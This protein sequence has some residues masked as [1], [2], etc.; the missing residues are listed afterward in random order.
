MRARASQDQ[1]WAFR[2]P[3]NIQTQV[4]QKNSALTPTLAVS[5]RN[6]PGQLSN[7]TDTHIGVEENVPK[8]TVEEVCLL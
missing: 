1:L 5:Q 7:G 3:P 2:Y 6:S 4:S 8:E